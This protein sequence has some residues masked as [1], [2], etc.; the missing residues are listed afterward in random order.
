MQLFVSLKFLEFG[1]IRF[2]YVAS[3]LSLTS[4]T[5]F[6]KMEDENDS[7]KIA[8]LPMEDK[9]AQIVEQL[10]QN[11]IYA[12]SSFGKGIDK[13]DQA[14]PLFDDKYQ[15]KVQKQNRYYIMRKTPTGWFGKS[16][17]LQRGYGN[18]TVEG[19]EDEEQLASVKHLVFFVHGVGGKN[20]LPLLLFI[21][22][23]VSND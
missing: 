18:Y 11:A 6:V 8:L 3:E 2:N 10:Y 22:C 1:K 9:D 23:L 21:L 7:G 13:I 5:W 4:A 14:T 15:V 17:D 19:E 20:F 16:Y 12:A